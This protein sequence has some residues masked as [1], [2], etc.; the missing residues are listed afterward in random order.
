M[1]SAKTI[2]R[3]LTALGI[4]EIVTNLLS[5]FLMILIARTLGGKGVGVYSFAFAFAGIFALVSGL[6]LPSLMVRD[7]SRDKSLAEKYLQNILAMRTI[8]CTITLL[9]PIIVI[10]FIEDDI[11]V[12]KNVIL[13][14]VAN[15]FV[16]YS[17]PFQ[18]LLRAYEQMAT[19]SVSRIVE[20]IIALSLGIF[21]LL[22]GYGLLALMAVLVLSNF[23]SFLVYLPK[24]S[25]LADIK[26]EF[27]YK[28]WRQL[29]KNGMPFFLTAFFLTLYFKIDIIMLSMIKDYSVTGIYSAAYKIIDVASKVPFIIIAVLF[30][31]MSQLHK[32]SKENLK[33]LYSKS[34]YYLYILALPMALG[35]TMLSSRIIL[36]VYKSEFAQSSIALQILI[37]AE[38]FIFLNFLMGFLLNSI[39]KQHI[40]TWCIG[41]GAVSNIVLNF[42]LIH[43]FSYIGAGIATVLTELIN[44]SIFAYF[45]ALYGF[46]FKFAK[47]V[48]KPL[49][50]SAMMGIFLWYFSFI[51]LL[52][53]IPLAIAVYFL[54]LYTIGGIGKE[55]FY[56]AKHIF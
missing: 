29:V 28:F 42:V 5:F 35:V 10:F 48:P 20:R 12:V 1:P 41:V 45:T 50:A 40:F 9:L 6:G 17:Y 52:F 24:A 15:F 55:E 46:K 16:I 47:I 37:W 7:I 36:F 56:M 26:F 39:D 2:V 23:V 3:N 38:F 43:Y 34:F 21:V 27:D 54:S 19:E 33:W 49:I 32:I 11:F 44:F 30:P 18:S 22:N 51:H 14:A 53:I 13:A 4:A 31:A 25:K 8:L